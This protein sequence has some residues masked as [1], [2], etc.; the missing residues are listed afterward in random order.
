[1]RELGRF[2][3]SFQPK[4][5]VMLFNETQ[6]KGA[7]TVEL[8]PHYDHRGFFARTFSAPEFEALGLNPSVVQCNLSFNRKK[9]T[10]RGMHYRV[11]PGTEAKV[12]RCTRGAIYD[13]IIDLRPHS[14]TYRTWIDIELDADNRR[15]LYIPEMCAHG[16]QTLVE[17]TEVF[18]QTSEI[19]MPQYERGVRY[20]DPAF[21]I[22]WPLPISEISE[23]DA[24]W[25]FFMSV[26][27]QRGLIG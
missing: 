13:V 5:A 1:M 26:D 20:N 25:P 14:A 24:T 16:F 22:E 27:V 11:A 23:K 2:G 21:E 18:Y 19:Y 15:A 6:I 10:L 4:G 17:H 9:G 3:L 7:Y 8:E 12:V